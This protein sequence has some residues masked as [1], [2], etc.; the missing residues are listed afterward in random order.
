MILVITQR[1]Q[2]YIHTKIKRSQI[3]EM[4]ATIQFK[5]LSSHLLCK[6]VEIKI[7]KTVTLLL[8]LY[9]YENWFLIL[10][11]EHRLRVFRR[12]C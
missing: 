12:E 2:N 11:Q 10:S 5:T 1:N 9:K 4:L 6:S 8:S 3:W 7:Q